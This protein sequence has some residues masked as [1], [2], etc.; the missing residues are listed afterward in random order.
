[1]SARTPA[2]TRALPNAVFVVSATTLAALAAWLATEV[3]SV[4]E[5]TPVADTLPGWERTALAAWMLAVASV[6]VLGPLAALAVWGRYGEVRR[7]LLP[8]VLVLA[9]QI[10]AEILLP[11]VVSPNVVVLTGLTFTGYRILQLWVCRRYF[12]ETG[13]P[14]RLGNAVV[15]GLLSVGLVFWTANG[16]FLM[17]VA[18]PG[19]VGLP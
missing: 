13:V 10:F 3:V 15:G 8:Y 4:L 2:A 5:E 19:V 1:M 9:F 16:L 17:L 12:L 14:D 11:A 6:S 18:L 7:V